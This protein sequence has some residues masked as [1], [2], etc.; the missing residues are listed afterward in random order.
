MINKEKVEYCLG[1][2]KKIQEGNNQN[3][4][5]DREEALKFYN[6]DKSIVAYSKNRSTVVT[7]D[8]MDAIEWIKPSL[9][10]IFTSGSNPTSIQGAGGE[11]VI[12]VKKLEKLVNY[13]LRIKNNWFVVLYDCIDDILKLKLGAIK[14]QWY[15]ETKYITKQYKNLTYEE[16]VVLTA[17]PNIEIISNETISEFNFNLTIKHAILD[18][19]PLIEAIPVEDFGIPY[20]AKDI[21]TAPFI[22]HRIGLRKWEVIKKYGQEKFNKIKEIVDSFE[23]DKRLENERFK[24]LGGKEF[25]F[26]EEEK[27][28]YI[29]EC[30]YPDNSTGEAKLNC[31]CGDVL[32]TD[33][34]NEYEQPPFVAGT[35]LKIG[36]RLIGL[37]YYDLLKELQKIKT[38]I[39]RQILNRVY[40]A[41]NPRYFGDTNRVDI[42]DYLYNT[43]PN[44]FIKIKGDPRTAIMP[45]TKSPMPPEVFAFYE[46]LN[47][48]KDYHSGVPRSFQGIEKKELNKTWRGASQQISQAAQRISL[49]ARTIAETIIAP[50]VND[51]INLNIKFLDKEISFRYLNENIKINP[52]NIVGK[53]DVIVNVGTG[54]EDKE[55][56]NMHMQQLFGIFATLRKGGIPIATDQNFYAVVKELVETMDKKNYQDFVTDPELIKGVKALIQVVMS[57]GMPQKDPRVAMLIQKLGIGFGL[58]QQGSIEA[59]NQKTEQPIQANQPINAAITPMGGEYFG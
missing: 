25:V 12:E 58:V 24:D 11:D 35:A 10:E 30:Y 17:A 28:Y 16:Y 13:Q 39:L 7:T 31:I 8:V 47:T 15:K 52:D 50:L 43:H 57:T 3:L 23:D 38:A 56:T 54:A 55:R 18:S 49:I 19:Y 33:E 40:E 29:Y 34:K 20:T 6:G 51:I 59:P 26:N 45:E 48:E 5:P 9:L 46:M 36:H 53:Y 21:K 4:T 27:T 37:S 42:K 44:A 41:N 32:L 22:Y 14:W 2:I 1:W